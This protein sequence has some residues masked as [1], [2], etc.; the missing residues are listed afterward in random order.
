MTILI[1]LF[2]ILGYLVGIVVTGI[3]LGL[4]GWPMLIKRLWDVEPEFPTIIALL[5]WP[6]TLILILVG[7][8]RGLK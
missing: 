2:V 8:F 1:V 7:G 4:L 3:Y 5:L 6:I